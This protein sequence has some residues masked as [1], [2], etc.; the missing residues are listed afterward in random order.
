MYERPA[1]GLTPALVVYLIDASDSMNERCGSSTKIALVNK[2]LRG[3]I[4]TMIRRSMRDGTV[5]SRYKIAIFAYSTKVIDILGG[6]HNLSDLMNS[7]L[8]ELS[9]GGVTD[10]AAAFESVEKLLLAHLAE[11]QRGPAPLVCHLTDAGFT[12]IDPTPYIRRIQAMQ[13]ED[14]PVL[15]ENIYIAENM[16][17]KPVQNWQE[18]GGV[19]RVKDI[20][21][22]YARFLY[23]LSSPLP[24][25]YRRNINNYGYH[26]QPGTR[27]FFPGFD[28]DLVQLAFAIS[29]ATELK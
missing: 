16:L 28:S 15:V 11:Y 23:T 7:G 20:N 12:T 17:R 14:G 5:Q 25:T 21:D 6:I 26:L 29:A 1:T 2:A 27:L 22:E 10:T 24:E 4:R 19:L 18:W 8:P 9:A 3:I 13:V